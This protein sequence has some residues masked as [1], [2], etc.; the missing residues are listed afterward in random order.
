MHVNRRITW[1]YA[2]SFT[3]FWE[4]GKGYLLRQKIN[5]PL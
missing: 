3:W 1:F 5:K 2:G 4:L